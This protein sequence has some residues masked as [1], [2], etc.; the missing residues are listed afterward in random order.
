MN[1]EIQGWINLYKP[2][3][4]SSFLAIKKIKNKFNIS[5]IGH[6]GTLDPLAEGILPVALGK[7]T[8]LIPFL[9][10]NLK[11]YIFT[12]KWGDQTSTDDSEGQI[13]N[14]SI[15]IPKVINIKK[16]L[17]NFIGFFEQVPPK[18]SAVKFN[19][20]STKVNGNSFMDSRN[21]NSEPARILGISKGIVTLKKVFQ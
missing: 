17:K 19:G 6:A 14:K 2:K 5:K 11:N 1:K 20:E 18:A 4:I 8:K 12:I 9:N 21:I 16:S 13:I 15:K 7:A 3:N 10:S